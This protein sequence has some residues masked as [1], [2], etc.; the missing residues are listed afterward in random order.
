M[1]S[2]ETLLLK[3]FDKKI[4]MSILSIV[5]KIY[6][7]NFKRCDM[8]KKTK[9]L[10]LLALLLSLLALPAISNAQNNGNTGLT[11]TQMEYRLNTKIDDRSWAEMT[12]NGRLTIIG[13]ASK[14]VDTIKLTPQAKKD[15]LSR[16]IGLTTYSNT[17]EQVRVRSVA[18]YDRLNKQVHVTTTLYA[19]GFSFPGFTKMIGEVAIYNNKLVVSDPIGEENSPQF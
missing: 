19:P 11:K 9:F 18:G 3:I 16:E 15:A 5:N 10:S 7:V 4:L 6:I 8:K 17:G 14:T 13:G 12:D 1:K 2:V